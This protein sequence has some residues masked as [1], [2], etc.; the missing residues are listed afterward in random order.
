V[1]S[2]LE[3]PPSIFYRVNTLHVPLAQLRSFVGGRGAFVKGA[4]LKLLRIRMP[5]LYMADPTAIELV[6]T[7]TPGSRTTIMLEESLRA[8]RDAGLVEQFAYR[9]PQLTDIENLAVLFATADRRVLTVANA[10][11][12]SAGR[13]T[14]AGVSVLCW[15]RVDDERRIT[16]CT[17]AGL[18]PP[19]PCDDREVMRGRSVAAIVARHL[20]RIARRTVLAFSSEKTGI[21]HEFLR[22]NR[23]GTDHLIARGIL[24]P[25]SADHIAAVRQ[26]FQ[27]AG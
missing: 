5:H 11:V 8:C 21:M 27:T 9:V 26:Q 16:T 12:A 24:E 3:S 22:M 17:F 6:S 1:P 18:A 10:T 4:V 14:S 15:S 25:M 19:V 23:K 20:E 13:K 2:P 7:V